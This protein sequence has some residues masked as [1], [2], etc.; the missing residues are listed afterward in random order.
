MKKNSH[1]TAL[2]AISCAFSTIAMTIGTLYSPMLFTGYLLACLCMMLPLSKGYYKGAV[3]CFVATNVLTL[4]FNGFNFFDTLPYTVFFGLHPVVNELQTHLREKKRSKGKAAE[5][6]KEE[7]PTREAKKSLSEDFVVDWDECVSRETDKK[8]KEGR[9]S[10]KRGEKVGHITAID[11]LFTVLK[12]CWFD[13][14]MYFV[15][16]VVFLANTSIAFVDAHIWLVILVG[17]SAFFLLYDQMTFRLRKVAGI[18]IDR[19]VKRK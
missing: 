18:W 1:E 3:L 10:A 13:A 6:K 2:S 9:K 8:K 15:W 12:I 19:Y 4:L 17:G 5:A 7:L 11:V 16:K 14:A